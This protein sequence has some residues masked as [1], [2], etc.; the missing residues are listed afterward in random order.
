MFYRFSNTKRRNK[1][2]NYIIVFVDLLILRYNFVEKGLYRNS[3]QLMKSNRFVDRKYFCSINL[4]KIIRYRSITGYI[5][6]SSL[7]RNLNYAGVYLL[8]FV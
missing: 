4:K 5:D 1:R 7:L 8:Y 3:Q 2:P 6:Y